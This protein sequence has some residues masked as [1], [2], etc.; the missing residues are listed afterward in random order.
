MKPTLYLFV[1][2]PGAGKTTIAQL[3]AKRT[4]AVHLWADRIRSEL[5]ENPTHSRQE[6]KVLYDKLNAETAAW[7]K[8][9]KSV[10]FDTN[11]N[12][13][14]DRQLLR[15]IADNNGAQTVLVWVTTPK[16]VSRKR[17][18]TMS[19]SRPTRLFGNMP[20][21]DFERM[22]GNLQPPRSEER[23]ITI[24]GSDLQDNT[25]YQALGI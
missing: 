6:S 18:V 20:L 1:G 21:S 11:F 12:F 14:D 16:D 24:D 25:V 5:F 13:Y 17:A 10:V 23:A 8:M 2:H 4:G 9:G 7:L 3:I 19:D 22:A 15:Q